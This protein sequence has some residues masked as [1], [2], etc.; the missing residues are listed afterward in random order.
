MTPKTQRK[1]K[2]YQIA[3][4]LRGLTTHA[5]E[6]DRETTAR[7]RTE[8]ETLKAGPGAVGTLYRVDRAHDDTLV[9]IYTARCVHK[10]K[11]GT[12]AVVEEEA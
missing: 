11:R 10:G 5:S 7:S 9:P 1:L 6:S 3:V 12:P 4:R 8:R 2:L